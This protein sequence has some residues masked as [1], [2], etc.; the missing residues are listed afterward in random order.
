MG[1]P[2]FVR[3]KASSVTYLDTDGTVFVETPL[4][5]VAL[6]MRRAPS[7]TAE[8]SLYGFSFPEAR[9]SLLVG[10]HLFARV[11][12]TQFLAGLNL[13]KYDGPPPG[14]SLSS[15]YSLLHSGVGFGTYFSGP[16][17]NL[18]FYAALDAFLRFDMPGYRIFFI[19]PVAPLGLSPTFGAE[20]GREASAKLFF[21]L[22]GVFYPY[23]MVDLMLASRG[24][25][26]GNLVFSGAGWFPGHPGWLGEF[27]LPR[28]GLKVYL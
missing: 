17:R 24:S 23:A 28:L 4:T 12:L 13:Q 1:I 2:A 14:L 7:W 26:S 19:D 6:S 25:S 27:P 16:E 20:W 21:E 18:R 8:L 3:W 22:G 5:R 9:V 15:S 11:A 10:K